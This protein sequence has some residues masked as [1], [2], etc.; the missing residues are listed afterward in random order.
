LKNLQRVAE[1]QP[2]INLSFI[3]KALPKSG[4]DRRQPDL[5]YCYIFRKMLCTGKAQLQRFFYVTWFFLDTDFSLKLIYCGYVFLCYCKQCLIMVSGSPVSM[6]NA[7]KTK[8]SLGLSYKI[9]SFTLRT[10]Y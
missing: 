1:M 2:T 5:Q 6:W 7:E 4:N 9:T 10:S 8:V 3:L